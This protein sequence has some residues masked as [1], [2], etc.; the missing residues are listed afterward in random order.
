MLT[1]RILALALFASHFT[2]FVFVVAGIHFILSYALLWRQNCEYFEGAPIKQKLFRCAI[3]YVHMFCFFPLEGKN[4]RKWGYPYYIVTFI[5]NS[6][7]VLLWNF[8]ASYNLKFRITMLTAEWTTFA[9]GIA[10]LVLFYRCFHPSSYLTTERSA[11]QIQSV[12]ENGSMHQSSST[13]NVNDVWGNRIWFFSGVVQTRSLSNDSFLPP[14]E[15]Y[16][17]NTNK[18]LAI[19]S[20]CVTAACHFINIDNL[21][22]ALEK[23]CDV[24]RGGHFMFVTLVV[25]VHKHPPPHPP[26]TPRQYKKV[27]QCHI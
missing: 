20:V 10:S 6:A 23:Y 18:K 19:K 2:R 8:V 5:E 15:N 17:Y 4:T 16:E 1:S 11:R 25:L 9:I 12:T 14:T 22:K 27:P 13:C 24:F 3:A 7:I 21:K 26:S